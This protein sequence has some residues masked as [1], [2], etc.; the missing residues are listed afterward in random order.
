M[1]HLMGIGGQVVLPLHYPA[2]LGGYL[3]GSRY[4]ALI[5]FMG[6]LL[7]SLLTGMPPLLPSALLMAPEIMTYG[8]IAGLLRKSF[9]IW[10][11]LVT[12]LLAGRLVWGLS[13]W[14]LAPIIGFNIPVTAAILAGFLT[15]LP[16]IIG[17][18]ILVP[19]LVRR[20]ENAL[21]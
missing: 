16:G 13:A 11:S 19:I 4:G 17:Q 8:L 5:G 12:A 20:I 6:P 3:L 14:L 18:L 10:G 1:L 9:G 7:S 15:G 2:L 21:R